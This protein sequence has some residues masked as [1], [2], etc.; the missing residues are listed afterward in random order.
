MRHP[1]NIHHNQAVALVRALMLR[2][3]A[4]YGTQEKLEAL[5]GVDQGSWSAYLSGRVKPSR[6]T[7]KVIRSKLRIPVDA[8]DKPVTTSEVA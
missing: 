3:K 6:H 4:R 1:A 8:W 7:R 5:T 2:D